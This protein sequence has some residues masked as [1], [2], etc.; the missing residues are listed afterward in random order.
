[1]SLTF[2]RNEL[3][4]P[5]SMFITVVVPSGNRDRVDTSA[6]Q[7]VT[8]TI[9]VG[10]SPDLKSFS[11]FNLLAEATPDRAGCY[12]A[13]YTVPVDAP[14][15]PYTLIWK[16][17]LVNGDTHFVEQLFYVE[18]LQG[19][20]SEGS[21]A[22]Y[23]LDGVTVTSRTMKLIKFVRI[24]LRD[25][26]PDRNYHAVPPRSSREVQGY[27]NRV[28]FIWTDEELLTYLQL[29]LADL[30]SNNPKSGRVFHIDN[31]PHMW[32]GVM[33][34]IACVRALQSLSINWAQD[35]FGYSIS[36]L[37]LDL[38]KADRFNGLR[39]SLESTL[40]ARKDNAT[41]I[42]PVSRGITPARWNI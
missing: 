4:G 33:V 19:L 30:N 17:N 32:L 29:S 13:P 39:T 28:G 22:A 26:N 40:Q 12:Y 6:V 9:Y 23:I 25:N 11:E 36:G 2:G 42:R 24:A 16:I 5:Q 10:K 14:F 31:F 18:D 35:E 38:N 1:M 8:Y 27:S 41:A 37:S 21:S 34:D 3:F 15:G 20:Q 7:S